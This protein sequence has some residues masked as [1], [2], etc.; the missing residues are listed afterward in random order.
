M[1]A[2][3]QKKTISQM[4][5]D[6]SMT[7]FGVLITLIMVCLGWMMRSHSAETRETVKTY[8]QEVKDETVRSMSGIESK[9]SILQAQSE[10]QRREMAELRD[11]ITRLETTVKVL[12]IPTLSEIKNDLKEKP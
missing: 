6:N 4:A 11:S 9:M 8:K 2:V 3:R 7:V 10:T 1:S 12:V 5:K